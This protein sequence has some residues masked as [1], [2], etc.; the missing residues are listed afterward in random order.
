LRPY[1]GLLAQWLASDRDDAYLLAGKSFEEAKQW[2]LTRKLSKEDYQLFE[3][4]VDG[5]KTDPVP[6]I[7]INNAKARRW[8]ISQNLPVVKLAVVAS[9]D[10]YETAAKEVL[11]GVAD[12]QDEFNEKQKSQSPLMEIVI[13]NDENEPE[14]ARKVAQDLV[15]DRDILGIIGHHSSESTKEAQKIYNREKISIISPSS[16]SSDL[17][18][19]TGVDND[20]F[21]RTVGDTKKAAKKYIAYIEKIL[22]PEKLFVFYKEKSAYSD[23]LRTDLE[24]ASKDSRY[25]IYKNNEVEM[26]SDDFNIKTAIYKISTPNTKTALII[27]SNVKTNSVA[28]AINQVNSEL[29]ALQ[30]LHLL[31]TMALSETETIEKGGASMEGA[32]F[33]RPCFSLESKYMKDSIKRWNLSELNWRTATSYDATKAFAKAIENSSQKNP[34]RKETLDRLKSPS[35]S[36][37][38]DETSGFGLEWDLSGDRSNKKSKYCIFRIESTES[39]DPKS[40]KNNRFEF[41]DITGKS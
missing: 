27:L 17:S 20:Q 22:K 39:K 41:V 36:L 37:T 9:I 5:D 14:A 8:S 18:T 33:I 32:I 31:G 25:P 19:Q 35:F 10:Y 16:S 15:D 40:P 3:Q 29:P 21:F 30:K 24:E 4:A 26:S 28:I 23:A 38:K 1:A 6:R 11:R 34:S 2:A 12:A 13:A 7:F